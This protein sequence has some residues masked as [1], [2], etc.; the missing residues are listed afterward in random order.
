[1]EI[2][3]LTGDFRKNTHKNT[4]RNTHK[5]R[6]PPSK[7][8]G[9]R[10]LIHCLNSSWNWGAQCKEKNQN[11]YVAH[12]HTHTNI[13]PCVCVWVGGA[14]GD[15]FYVCFYVCFH[16]NRALEPRLPSQKLRFCVWRGF[17]EIY[18]TH[19]ATRVCV[20]G[21]GTKIGSQFC[22]MCVFTEMA[23]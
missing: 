5:K 4:H 10:T 1:M 8:H 13:Y 15:S 3:A 18:S 20:L 11:L 9:S 19:S 7:T 17:C 14:G 2:S 23:R 22:F 21:G 12:T 6:S 16:G